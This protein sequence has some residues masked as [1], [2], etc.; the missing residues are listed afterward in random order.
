MNVDLFQRCADVHF[1]SQLQAPQARAALLTQL[2]FQGTSLSPAEVHWGYEPVR[3]AMA[4][5]YS[6]VP[7]PPQLAGSELRSGS[8]AATHMSSGLGYAQLSNGNVLLLGPRAR[9]AVGCECPTENLCWP[10]RNGDCTHSF[11]RWTT[12]SHG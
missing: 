4:A 3:C 2:V 6:D 12:M 10:P 7:A 9:C 1:P 5:G 8:A 11:G